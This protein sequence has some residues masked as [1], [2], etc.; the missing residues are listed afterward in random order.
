MFDCLRCFCSKLRIECSL[1]Q[2]QCLAS[3]L[4]R[5]HLAPAACQI[6]Q[7]RP[8]KFRTAD[9]SYRSAL[10][11]GCASCF[12]SL[13]HVHVE[14]NDALVQDASAALAILRSA[15]ALLND[16]GMVL[17]AIQ[18]ER[19]SLKLL[20]QRR[21]PLEETWIAVDSVQ[22]AWSA[23][24]DMVVRGAPA[25]AIAAALALAAQLVASDAGLQFSSAKEAAEHV[26]EELRY[27]VTR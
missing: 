21:L 19:G 22:T 3:D 27:L 18:Y 12:L 6:A 2:D 4:H 15:T 11:S 25:I 24:K 10:N 23:I 26:K 14:S 20:D 8:D 9:G 16:L 1:Q 13:P 7:Q 5:H 17:Q